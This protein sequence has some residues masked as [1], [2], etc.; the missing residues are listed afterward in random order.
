MT[1][2]LDTTPPEIEDAQEEPASV[3]VIT[4]V[5][6]ELGKAKAKAIK[7]LKKGR[8]RLM[9]EVFDVLDEVTETLG[10]ELEGKTLVP[11]VMVY[12]KKRK[13]KRNRIVLP[14]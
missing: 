11:I 13:R 7:R 1:E 9:N 3:E 5:V 4:P 10:D 14:F 12:R 2:A 6:V 8:G